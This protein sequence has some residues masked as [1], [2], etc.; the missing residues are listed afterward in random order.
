ML[1]IY[2]VAFHS[3]V[4][5]LAE[6]R[7]LA[8]AMNAFMDSFRTHRFFKMLY[9]EDVALL[10]ERPSAPIHEVVSGANK[11]LQR[12]MESE[13]FSMYWVRY[14]MPDPRI[15][16]IDDSVAVFAQPDFKSIDNTTIYDV[17]TFNVESMPR[18]VEERVEKQMKVFQ[19]AYPG[20]RAVV[21]GI[22]YGGGGITVREYEPPTFQEVEEYLTDLKNVCMEKGVVKRLNVKKYEAVRYLIGD[23]T[24]SLEVFEKLPL[25]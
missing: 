16:I 7:S 4:K 8:E 21:L 23:G 15:I 6:S 1:I 11:S 22:P 10:D 9:S 12:F 19:L 17:K 3:A 24:V 14:I 5:K 20:S 25:S 2:G 18:E 13:L